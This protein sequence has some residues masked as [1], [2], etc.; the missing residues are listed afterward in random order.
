MVTIQDVLNDLDD[1]TGEYQ[2]GTATNPIKIRHINKA[3][4]WVKRKVGLPSDEVKQTI[5]WSQDQ[6]FYD[7]ESDV[8]ELLYMYWKKQS[9]N[10]HERYWTN[11]GNYDEILKRQGDSVK[12]FSFAE[13]HI[14]GSKQVAISGYNIT[15]PSVID[16]MDEVGTWVVGGDSSALTLDVYNKYSGTGSLSFTVTNSSGVASIVDP[17]V[18]LNID[19]LIK[20]N[21]M[22]KLWQHLSDDDIDDVTLYLYTDDSNYW[23]ITETDLDDSTAFSADDWT[24]VGFPMENRVATGTPTASNIT[25]IRI[26]YDLGSGFTTGTFKI[27]DIFLAYPDELELVYKTSI[28]GTDSTGAVN[29]TTLTEVTDIVKLGHDDLAELVAHKAALRIWPTLKGDKEF[30]AAY[31][32]LEKE[33]LGDFARRYP[34]KRTSGTRET[35]FNRG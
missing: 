18:S 10:T 23:T 34:R 3:I 7:L 4:E 27:D 35:S 16:S 9:P 6:I 8:N 29:K 15:P 24:K 21:G 32:Q 17:S 22:I 26:E 31:R 28:K 30:W 33:L 12:R 19:Q 14:N 25:K 1:L 2:T 20:N 11:V 5:N 13:T